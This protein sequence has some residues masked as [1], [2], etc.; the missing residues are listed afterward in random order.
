MIDKTIYSITTEETR[1]ILGGV[2]V[3]RIT[4]QNIN[5]LR[6]T[7]TDGH[8]LSL[9]D[10]KLDGL[11]GV[12]IEKGVIISRKGLSEMKK[13]ADEGGNLK[14]AFTSNSAI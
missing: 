4:N 13:M 12:D 9:V 1:Y 3:E 6:F 11:G 5:F 2:F 14:L 7:S 8:R 10:S